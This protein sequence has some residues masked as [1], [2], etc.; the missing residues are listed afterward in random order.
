VVLVSSQWNIYYYANDFSID[1]ND[2]NNDNG[3]PV[4]ILR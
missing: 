3:M 1:D 2:Y 4:H